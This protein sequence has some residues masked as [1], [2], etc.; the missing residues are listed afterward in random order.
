MG[1][2]NW[3][4]V[5]MGGLLAGVTV[6]VLGYGAWFLFLGTRW[7]AALEALGRPLHESLASILV[8]IISYFVLGILAVWL[9]ALIRPRCGPGPKTAMLGGFA[10]WLLSGLLPTIWWGPGLFS[11]RLLTIDV[12]TY[13]VI[14][15]VAT[16]L[17]GWLYKE[18][19]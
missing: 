16:V 5:L 8:G 10:I 11:A 18:E 3:R 13:L 14:V 2:I 7:R 6:N 9:Y 1:K 17:G 19:A 12:L 4:R 15:L